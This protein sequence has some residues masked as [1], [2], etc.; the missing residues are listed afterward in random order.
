MIQRLP[1]QQPG[2]NS[3]RGRAEAVAYRTT[4]AVKRVK[5]TELKASDSDENMHAAQDGHISP[6]G[7]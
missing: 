6:S 4:G 1:I 3:A 5:Y 7:I 2:R